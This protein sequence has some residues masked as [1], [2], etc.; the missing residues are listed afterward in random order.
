MSGDDSNQS[1]VERARE[2]VH[3]CLEFLK[4]HGSNFVDQAVKVTG[5]T[6]LA[7]YSGTF[8]GVE[9]E[10]GAGAKVAVAIAV[11]GYRIYRAIKK[12]REKE[13]EDQQSDAPA[14]SDG[15]GIDDYRALQKNMEVLLQSHETVTYALGESEKANRDLQAAN[16]SLVQANEE[17]TNANGVLKSTLRHKYSGELKEAEDSGLIERIPFDPDEDALV[18]IAYDDDDDDDNFQPGQR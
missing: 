1:W 15:I 8:V 4:E 3:N 10:D 13:Q 5:I 14:P 12:E 18:A 16:A 11:I 7:S 2:G 17:L 9:M 6:A